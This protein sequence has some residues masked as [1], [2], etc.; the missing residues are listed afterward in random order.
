MVTFGRELSE[1]EIIGC[2]AE[3]RRAREAVDGVLERGSCRIERQYLQAC[4]METC[5]RHCDDYNGRARARA[6]AFLRWD[7]EKKGVYQ[8]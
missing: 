4:F 5:S 3:G 7:D 2:G 8:H 6:R 1:L